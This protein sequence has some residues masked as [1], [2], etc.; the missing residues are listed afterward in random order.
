MTLALLLSSH[1]T[2]CP[3]IVAIFSLF[4]RAD[5][6][7]AR[8]SYFVSGL[9]TELGDKHSHIAAY[10]TVLRVENAMTIRK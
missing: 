7:R 8:S 5:E 9:Y 2:I 6:P 4:V 10:Y 3:C 1:R